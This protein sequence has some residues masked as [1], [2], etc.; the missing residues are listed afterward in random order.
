M[1]YQSYVLIHIDEQTYPP[2]LFNATESVKLPT[3][4][5]E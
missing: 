2:D 3:W 4:Q 1:F 5:S